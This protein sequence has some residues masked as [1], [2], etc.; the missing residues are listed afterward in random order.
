[1]F[2]LIL[3]RLDLA[4]F[5]LSDIWINSL[6]LD[7]KLILKFCNLAKLSVSFF[8]NAGKFELDLILFSSALIYIYNPV[9]YKEKNELIN[10]K[11]RTISILNVN[12]IV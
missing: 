9:E 6:S 10:P 3:F 8:L 4:L 5:W 7:D 1:M 11:W 12:T 2:S